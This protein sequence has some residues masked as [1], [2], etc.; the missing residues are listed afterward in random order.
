MSKPKG[1]IIRL[2]DTLEAEGELPYRRALAWMGGVLAGIM[3]EHDVS[4][5][6]LAEATDLDPNFITALIYGQ[7]GGVGHLVWERIA[8]YLDVPP[9]IFDVPEDLEKPI[10]FDRKLQSARS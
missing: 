9:S 5:D 10:K 7:A 4:R 3:R 6:E 8:K 1:K 2:E